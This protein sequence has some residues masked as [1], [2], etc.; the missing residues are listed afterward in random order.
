MA[1]S[2]SKEIAP[3]KLKHHLHMQSFYQSLMVL[4]LSHDYIYTYNW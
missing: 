2:F 3:E 1:E 4:A